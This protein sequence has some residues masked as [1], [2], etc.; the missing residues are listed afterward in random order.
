MDLYVMVTLRSASARLTGLLIGAAQVLAVV[1]EVEETK[2]CP[3]P[4]P[5]GSALGLEKN[6]IV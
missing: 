6:S 5:E 3:C 4:N 1:T 2:V